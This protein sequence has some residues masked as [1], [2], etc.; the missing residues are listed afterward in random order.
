M[1]SVV[2]VKP[3]NERV[4][5]KIVWDVTIDD[6]DK[7]IVYGKRIL[8]IDKQMENGANFVT[9]LF[10]EMEGIFQS[11]QDE[12][13]WSEVK[14]IIIEATK[15]G[16][17]YLNKLIFNKPLNEYRTN[18]DAKG[19]PLAIKLQRIDEMKK[20]YLD[21]MESDV[22]PNLEDT[23]SFDELNFN[24]PMV[25]LNTNIPTD[26]IREMVMPSLE[27][28]PN[29]NNQA[30]N[31]PIEATEQSLPIM[32]DL[33]ANSMPI[34][35]T[36]QSLPIMPDLNANSMPIVDIPTPIMTD[37]LE[38]EMPVTQ[39]MNEPLVS[40]DSF[41]DM[42]ERVDENEYQNILN[43]LQGV[44]VTPIPDPTQMNEFT[45]LENE[46]MPSFEPSV[47]NAPIIDLPAVNVQTPA[48]DL[49]IIQGMDVRTDP[50]IDIPTPVTDFVTPIDV[51]KSN[52]MQNQFVEA[53]VQQMNNSADL[54]TSELEEELKRHENAIKEILQKYN[55]L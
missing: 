16:S 15:P 43:G 50:V 7:S 36:E 46:V 30:I 20:M 40:D 52:M 24:D 4:N 6:K 14:S 37:P 10:W 29:F 19:R 55:E 3:T 21:N 31:N 27:P 8:M 25:D 53:P 18:I 1:E 9:E 13:A 39:A 2:L 38:A 17:E 45:S 5:E 54:R 41:A 12:S 34:V 51:P 32:P 42:F 49:P 48:V 11:I 22:V 44:N 35:V 26:P 23:L 47:N 33:N 28:V